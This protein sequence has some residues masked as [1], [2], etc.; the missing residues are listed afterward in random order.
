M[1]TNHQSLCYAVA[2]CYASGAW[3]SNAQSE[4]HRIFKNLINDPRPAIKKIAIGF[5]PSLFR[6]EPA[7]TLELAVALDSDGDEEITDILIRVFNGGSFGIEPDSLD[8]DQLR[9]LL[10]KLEPLKELGRNYHLDKFLTYVSERSPL[11]L[12]NLFIGR[13]KRKEIGDFQYSPVPDVGL[14]AKLKGIAARTDYPEIVR[15]IRD[16]YLTPGGEKLYGLP[17]LFEAVS[18]D[19]NEEGLAALNEWLNSNDPT[20]IEAALLLLDDVH[21]PF[22]FE[23][24]DFVAAALRKAEAAGEE[25][26]R[27]ARGVFSAGAILRERNRIIGQPPAT[28]VRQLEQASAVLNHLQAGTPEYRF[29]EYVV[30]DAE[31]TLEDERASDEQLAEY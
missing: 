23:H 6:E 13:L 17:K 14:G 4:E 27:T 5:L 31:R 7:L 18:L 16:L 10:S 26:R 22:S 30:Q 28:V 1:E 25:C 20:K 2:Q 15:K 21:P 19:Y 9:A 24:V 8:D 3:L 11:D 12:L 29:Y